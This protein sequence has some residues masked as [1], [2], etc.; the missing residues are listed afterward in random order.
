M[1]IVAS[2]DSIRNLPSAAMSGSLLIFFFT[3]SALLFL[4]PTGLVA[5]E[6]AARHPDQGGIYHWVYRAFG[7]GPALLAIW[8]QWINTMVWYPTILSFIGGTAAY[9]INP[10]LAQNKAY[11]I[12]F[13]LIVFW[14]VTLLN[15]KGLHFSAKINSICGMIGTVIPMALLILLGAFWFFMKKPL[16]ISFHTQDLLPSFSHSSNFVS[17]IAMM[18]SFLGMELAGVHVTDIENPKKNFPKAVLF[19][20]LFILLTMVLGSLSI[21]MV[22]PSEKI[23]LISGVMQVLSAFFV[24]FH[25][26]FLTPIVTTLIVIGLSGSLINWLISPA[27]GLL[28]AAEFGYLPPFFTRKN[29][30]GVP[31]VILFAQAILVSL[32]CLV[33][34]LVPSINGFYW[35]LTALSTGLYMIMY[36]L[37]FFSAIRLRYIE[38]KVEKTFQVPGKKMGIWITSLVG[39]FAAFATIVVSFI[40]PE[41]ISVG[42]SH[43]YVLMVL[44]ANIIAI[45]PVIAMIYYRETRKSTSPYQSSEVK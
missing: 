7:K 25:L 14:S 37:M 43:R 27:K 35:F 26:D 6:L 10:E 24:E 41:N 23:N 34:L 13:I 31:V 36:L 2:I 44:G 1:L 16:Q 38:P 4:V 29:E 22:V 42:S 33:F 12:L 19:S 8:M 39:S 5:A 11:L 18:A 3:I 40:P 21:A 17:L 9:L 32:L 20:S 30:K 15:F 45:L 28:H